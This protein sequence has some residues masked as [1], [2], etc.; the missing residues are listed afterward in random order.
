MAHFRSAA[1]ALWAAPDLSRRGGRKRAIRLADR[2]A[3]EAKIEALYQLCGKLIEL[4]ESGYPMPHA[5]IADPL[6]LI[7]VLGYPCWDGITWASLARNASA[8]GRRLARD[9]APDIGGCYLVV[10]GMARGIDTAAH[11]GAMTTGTIAV[12]AGGV[13]VTYPRE[14]QPLYEDL[15]AHGAVIAEQPFGTQPIARHFPLR[16]RLI[17]GLFLGILVVETRTGREP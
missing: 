4:G 9:I 11:Q 8:A 12:V 15:L 13:D 1:E 10:L 17:S 6:P 2:A 7:Q 14:N 5:A 16:N 3:A